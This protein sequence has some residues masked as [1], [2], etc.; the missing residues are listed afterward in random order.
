[1]SHSLP[2]RFTPVPQDVFEDTYGSF[3]AVLQLGMMAISHQ[4]DLEFVGASYIC[5]LL[6]V[7]LYG[8]SVLQVSIDRILL[9]NHPVNV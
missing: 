8:M 9:F 6:T 5:C 2:D 3:C 4:N 1:M 7:L